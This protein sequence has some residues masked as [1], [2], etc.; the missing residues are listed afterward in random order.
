MVCSVP[1][2]WP[3]FAAALSTFGPKV[4]RTLSA[5][6]LSSSQRTG[7]SASS[8]SIQPPGVRFLILVSFV[9]GVM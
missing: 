3:D 8:C 5:G 7:A 9:G 1:P 6:R 4:R 2:G